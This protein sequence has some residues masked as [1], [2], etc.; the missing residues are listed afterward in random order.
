[1]LICPGGSAHR[2]EKR[3]PAERFGLL[4]KM[5]ADYRLTPVL[6][7]TDS[8]AEVLDRISNMCPRAKNLMGRTDFI[9]IASLAQNA[10]LAIGNDTGPVHL[11][12][13]VGAPTIVLFSEASNP[14]MCAPRGHSRDAVSIIEQP[15]LRNLPITRVFNVIRKRLNLED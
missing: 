1:V 11:A 14:K 10:V 4:A 15:D 8:E 9:E 3:W 6:I 5:L 2:P 13:A 12:A 7:G